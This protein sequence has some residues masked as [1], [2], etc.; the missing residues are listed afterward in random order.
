MD[1]LVVPQV[2]I[3]V[4]NA[5][6]VIVTL[7]RFLGSDPSVSS[8]R[9]WH[10]PRQLWIRPSTATIIRTTTNATQSPRPLKVRWYSS[11]RDSKRS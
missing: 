3:T 2:M 6:R 7:P 10:V 1:T 4:L 8:A 5:T 11:L 9:D